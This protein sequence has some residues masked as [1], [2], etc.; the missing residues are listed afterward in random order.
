MVLKA[1]Y[2]IRKNIDAS[3][4]FK[5]RYRWSWYTCIKFLLHWVLRFPLL[6][7]YLKGENVYS[8]NKISFVTSV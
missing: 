5:I 6:S 8:S 2:P 7:V 4:Y 1:D 3:W